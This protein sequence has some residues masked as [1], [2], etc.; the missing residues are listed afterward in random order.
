MSRGSATWLLYAVLS[1]FGFLLNGL[2]AILVPLQKDLRVGRD[3]V[4]FYP[5]LFA[6]GLLIVGV[7]GGLLVGR[8]GRAV[9]LRLSIGGMIAGGLLL[10]TSAQ[11][12]TLLGALLIGVGGALLIQ[13]IPAL[14]SALHP[15][16]PAAAVGE[17]NGLASAASV[18][19][20]LMVGGALAA[21][22]GWRVGYLVVPLV[23]LVLVLVPAWRVPLPAAE[24]P[25]EDA[26]RADVRRLIGP[27]VEVLFAVSVEFC[28]VFWAASA[29]TE[30]H[31]ASDGL[32][33][34]EASLFLVGMATGRSLAVPVTRRLPRARPLMLVC[35]AVAAAGFAVFWTAPDL[36]LAGAGLLVTGLGVALLYPTTV[37]RTVAAWPHAPDRAA[38]RA[39]LASGVAIGGAPFVLARLA[40]LVGLRIAYLVVPLLLAAL[41][42]RTLTARDTP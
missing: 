14:L 6:V 30:W 36:L 22:M 8:V 19:A 20:P 35:V 33:P 15:H 10:A 11:A 13:L 38:A 26:P 34:A 12:L 21:G 31:H 27:W 25:A 23:M 32:A 9:A 18:L 1:C 7:F 40:D 29:V 24:V 5:T 39:A 17:A 42:V 4:A 37:S 28:M 3:Q 2:G 41:V 16:A